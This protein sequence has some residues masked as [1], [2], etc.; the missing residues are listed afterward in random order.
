M[1]LPYLDR[2]VVG[3]WQLAEGH[4]TNVEDGRTVLDAYAGAGFRAFDAAD[5]YTGVEALLG[6][7]VAAHGLAGE[8]RVHTKLVP[9]LAALPTLTADDV[10]RAVDRS[11]ARL[12]VDALDLVQ[13]HWWDLAVPGYLEALDAL[14][15]QRRQGK[16]REIGLTN[17]DRARLAEILDHGVPIASLQ[18][19]VSLLDRRTR[20]AFAELAAAHGVDLLAYG[21]VAGGL[22]SDAWLDRPAPA[23]TP[24][25]RSLVKYLLVVEELGGWDA[26]Q[27]LL[28]ELREVADARGSDVATV[29]SGWCLR[30]PGVR[31]CIVGVR[32][33]RHL[34]RHVELRDAPP[35]SD[36]EAGRL[37]RARAAFPE[38]PGEVYALERDREGRHGRVM[39]YGLNEARP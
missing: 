16:V 1:P 2:V 12:R 38:V 34:A 19:Q 5:I 28:R 4:G 18:A 26:L 32:S 17:F 22:L 13:F 27:S 7:F 8:V 6:D 25:N 23:G 10:A 36:A 33:R 20:G 35:L 14:V 3:C 21:S 11:L 39:K 24:E 15:E 37:E 29:A 9:D 31:A 30:Q